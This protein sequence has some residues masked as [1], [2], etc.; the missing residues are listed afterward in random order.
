[1]LQHSSQL[2]A[3][4]RKRPNQL[5]QEIIL[6][7]LKLDNRKQQKPVAKLMGE[8]IL[9]VIRRMVLTGEH[10]SHSV[11]LVKNKVQLI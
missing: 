9:T 4:R 7:Q 11:I 10:M 1:M 8:I 6:K 3:M 2:S 5:K